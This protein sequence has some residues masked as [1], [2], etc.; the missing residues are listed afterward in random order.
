VIPFQS[1]SISG[2]GIYSYRLLSVYDRQGCFHKAEN[3]AQLYAECVEGAVTI[4]CE[5]LDTHSDL[6]QI[7][8]YPQQRYIY[9]GNLIVISQIAGKYFY[10]HYPADSLNNLSA[11]KL[12]EC[13]PDSVL[14][15][16]SK[17][18]IDSTSLQLRVPNSINNAKVNERLTTVNSLDV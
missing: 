10:D 14:L 18:S 5:F 13:E 16:S 2:H 1:G 17:A 3:P 12:F 9:Q 8:D 4:A 7:P 11:P 15:G 6:Q